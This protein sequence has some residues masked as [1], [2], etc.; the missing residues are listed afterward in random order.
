MKKKIR[1]TEDKIVRRKGDKEDV[2]L[3][4]ALN[5]LKSWYIFQETMQDKEAV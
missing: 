2:Q 3:K 1:I 4:R 5:Y